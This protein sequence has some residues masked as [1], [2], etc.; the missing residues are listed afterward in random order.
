MKSKGRSVLITENY[1]YAKLLLWKMW[2]DYY[3]DGYF[4]LW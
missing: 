3:I 2:P 1:S 4:I